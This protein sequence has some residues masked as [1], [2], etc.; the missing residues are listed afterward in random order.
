MFE[1]FFWAGIIDY[2]KFS[3]AFFWA[4]LLIIFGILALLGAGNIPRVLAGIFL[5]YLGIQ[6][7]VNWPLGKERVVQ[8]IYLG[9]RRTVT[10]DTNILYNKAK[11]WAIMSFLGQQT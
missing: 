6:L 7:T 10:I 3:E 9:K 11:P 8:S 5:I 1:A 4:S 2:I